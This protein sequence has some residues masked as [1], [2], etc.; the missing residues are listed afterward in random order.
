MI[1][2]VLT[3]LIHKALVAIKTSDLS[4]IAHFIKH[5]RVTERAATA[6]A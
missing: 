1:V 3:G 5:H 4:V 2:V 6:I